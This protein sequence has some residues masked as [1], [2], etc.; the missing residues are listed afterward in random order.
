MLHQHMH[1]TAICRNPHKP[2]K[3]KRPALLDRW[4]TKTQSV[5]N[6]YTKTL[7]SPYML[8]KK[9]TQNA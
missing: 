5:K 9:H 1:V 8:V 4:I 2:S 6:V 3:S 7:A